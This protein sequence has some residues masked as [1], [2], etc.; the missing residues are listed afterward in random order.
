MAQQGS[1]GGQIIDFVAS[2]G[3]SVKNR[4]YA[5]LQATINEG[6]YEDEEI[7]RLL[8]DG[9]WE[10]KAKTARVYSFNDANRIVLTHAGIKPK[11]VNT[12]RA[13]AIAIREAYEEWKGSQ[14]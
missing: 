9:I 14:P 7:Y 6:K 4:L 10:F 5:I 12:A 2:A 1:G 3:A 13:K 11:S 8:G